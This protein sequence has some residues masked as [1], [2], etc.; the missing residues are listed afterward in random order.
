M[1]TKTNSIPPR[2][3]PIAITSLQ[4]ATGQDPILDAIANHKAA[5]VSYSTACDRY[6]AIADLEGSDPRLLRAERDMDTAGGRGDN[7][8]VGPG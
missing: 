1:S 7:G 4:G 3:A 5:R 8:G 2:S 6:E